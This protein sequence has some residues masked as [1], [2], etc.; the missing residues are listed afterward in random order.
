MVCKVKRCCFIVLLLL[1]AFIAVFAGS[2]DAAGKTLGLVYPNEPPTMD[3]QLNT[4]DYMVPYNVFDRLVEKVADPATREPK[5]IPGLAESWSVSKDGK[6]YTFKLRKNAKFSDGTPVKASDVLYTFNR[7]FD[8]A[9]K[10]LQTSYF[11][12]IVGA[13]DV[14]A[15]KKKTIDGI[16]ADGDYTVQMTLE[17]PFP[18]FV[19][20]NITD[21]AGSIY[22]EKFTKAKGDKFGLSPED[23]MGSGAYVLKEWVLDSY[24]VLEANPNYWRGKPGADTVRIHIA[25]DPETARMMFETGDIDIFDCDTAP[26]QIPYFR[27]SAKWKKHM[28]KTL[29]IGLRYLAMNVAQPPLDNLNVRKALQMAVPRKEILD[30]VYYGTGVLPHNILAKGTYPYQPN[31]TSKINYDPAAAKKLLEKSGLKLPVAIEFSFSNAGSSGRAYSRMGELLQAT[32]GKAGF[33]VKVSP[34]DEAVFV[35]K[36]TSGSLMLYPGSRSDADADP[37]FYKFF[38]SGKDV[39]MSRSRSINLNNPQ[40]DKLI[41]Q[42]RSELNPQKRID[43]YRE[44]DNMITHKLAAFL[45]LF[46]MEHYFVISPKVKTFIPNVLGWG[47]FMVYWTEMN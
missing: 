24:H 43:E 23:T 31:P 6:V 41:L 30:A 27:G 14:L 35:D 15:G 5:L 19:D 38:Y 45:P 28:V 33:V 9:T 25:G 21:P 37:Y 34:L 3:V 8:P 44:L 32:M 10:S 4:S 1:A 26:S 12:M 40:V 46:N 18:P 2:A 7:M 39:N 22:S 29:R 42:A 16:K 17:E 47:D 36:R 11:D 13:K 20:T